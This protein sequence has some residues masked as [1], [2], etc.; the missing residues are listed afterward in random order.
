MGNQT[1]SGGVFTYETKLGLIN[2]N[3]PVFRRPEAAGRMKREMW[4]PK[5]CG[6]N[7]EVENKWVTIKTRVIARVIG[8]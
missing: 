7:W 1:T 6:S 8:G 4:Q 3:I 2:V 5:I